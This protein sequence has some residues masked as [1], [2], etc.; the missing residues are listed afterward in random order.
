MADAVGFGSARMDIITVNQ[1]EV[2]KCPHC[3]GTGICKQA[4][5]Q[6]CGN[7]EAVYHPGTGYY[8]YEYRYECDRCG[9]GI[10]QTQIQRM[11]STYWEQE[12]KPPTCNVCS[13]K[14]YTRV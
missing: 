7:P 8:L 12:P 2:I 4:Q 6:R 3:D 5:I 9:A 14:G 10:P 1:Q 13:G 11:F